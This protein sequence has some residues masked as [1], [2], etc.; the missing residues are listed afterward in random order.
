MFIPLLAITTIAFFSQ[1]FSFGFVSDDFFYLSFT[2]FADVISPIEGFYH[3]SPV[4]WMLMW[5]L[6]ILFGYNPL[7]FHITSVVLHLV[8]VI[9]FYKVTSF[10]LKDKLSRYF[11]SIIFAFYFA[12]YE[13]VYWV[14][15]IDMSLMISFYLLGFLAFLMYT[16]RHKTRFLLFYYSLFTIA[17]L[18]HEYATSL[19]FI[20]LIYWIFFSKKKM[21][22]KDVMKI[23][24][25]PIV[26]IM[27]LVIF[28]LS[29][30]SPIFVHG[31]SALRFLTSIVKSFLYILFPFPLII[32][33][34]SQGMQILLF[35]I[36]VCRLVLKGNRKKETLFLLVWMFII[37]S[38][39]SVSSLP[40][41]RYLSLA[42]I[43]AILLFL[44]LFQVRSLLSINSLYLIMI[45]ISGI[46]FLNNQKIYWEKGSRISR[47][48][49]SDVKSLYPDL[50]K[51]KILYFVNLPDSV[52]GPPW[53]AYVFRNGLDHALAHE[54]NGD[55]PTLS[56]RRTTPIDGKV[57]E[58]EPIEI[59]ELRKLKSGGNIVFV[60]DEENESVKIL[61]E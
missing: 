19:A 56:Y 60:F 40:Q 15:G 24:A 21:K 49:V 36:V 52:N 1:T 50:P 32:D 41:A 54:Y 51:G 20:T 46:F 12:H 3:Y 39:Y 33:R 25:F 8:N 7:P 45:F 9:I 10:F 57:R 31:P 55:I 35:L 30:S 23:V 42:S 5:F 43:P 34:L 38:V 29:D 48:V 58:D 61:D 16:K 26:V 22:T 44:R 27:I 4:F 11:S 2:R 6:K 13:I 28:K 18:T 37:V 17:I 47:N 59:E 53:N 14:T